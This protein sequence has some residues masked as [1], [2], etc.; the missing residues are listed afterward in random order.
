MRKRTHARVSIRILALL[1]V[2]TAVLALS[3]SVPSL[4]LGQSSDIWSL[5]HNA[6]PSF[7][8]RVPMQCATGTRAQYAS[9]SDIT[10]GLVST[11]RTIICAAPLTGGGGASHDLSSDWTLA[12]TAPLTLAQGGPG[13]STA[14]DDTVLISNGTVY[15]S[16]TL[17]NCPDTSG[18]HV[19]YTASSNTFS[20]GTSGG[21]TSPLTISDADVSPTYP[22]VGDLRFNSANGLTLSDIG[23]AIVVGISGTGTGSTVVY[24][25]GPVLANITSNQA[26]NGDAAITS[27]RATDTVPTGNFLV[28][29]NAAGATLFSIDT[30]GSQ[31]A[32]TV[33]V[34][35]V[36]G[37]AA[38]ATTD[39]TS[40]SNIGSGTL[41]VARGGTGTGSTLA[42]LIRGSGSAMTAA[43]LSGD[44]V[45][46][47]SNAVTVGKING[48]SL[49]GLAT[50]ILKNTTTT[51]LPSIAVAADFPTLNQ[52]TTGTAAGLS[53]TNDVAHGG[54]GAIT[55]AIHGVLLG[56]ATSTVN[57]TSPG[58][59][60]QVLTSNGPSAD[61]TF[62]T[63][64][65]GGIGGSTG[66]ATNR[67]IRAS[68]TGGATIQNST[69]TVDD[70]GN[71]TVGAAAAGWVNS[72]RRWLAPADDFDIS[73]GLSGS[74][75]T[76]DGA[77]IGVTFS[78]PAAIVGEEFLVTVDT[79]QSVTIQAQSGEVIY[80]GT[81]ASSSGGTLTSSTVG[82]TVLITCS[83]PGRW[84]TL[85]SGTWTAG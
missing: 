71:T 55:L 33:P 18:Q 64:A 40:A 31:T 48:V 37:L 58:T 75:V 30:T 24:S 7:S 43:E 9:I 59:I 51:G 85:A 77:A 28:F 15:Q 42:G 2:S 35:R 19:N 17:P 39:T 53:A 60:G 23:G 68:G 66:A 29:K 80:L 50:G 4:V 20:C 49:A 47:G 76:N 61:A 25:T 21:S 56:N 45:T 57:V 44:A 78:L 82:S 73:S 69:V 5:S 54:T 70:T 22:N 63:I 81:T 26:S 6:S 27:T 41:A 36:T 13:L 38:S 83:K 1:V 46:S 65:S 11:T 52:N 67:L 14:A 8:C 62:Q 79:A 84:K 3:L 10:F 72:R 32:G 16:K 34:A 12:L 74:G